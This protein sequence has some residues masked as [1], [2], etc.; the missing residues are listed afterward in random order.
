M[1]DFIN[2]VDLLGDN[3][4]IDSI[5]QR[6]IA[7]FKDDKLETIGIS[8]FRNCSQLTTVDLPAARTMNYHAFADCTSLVDVNLPLCDKVHQYGFNNCTSLTELRLPSVTQLNNGAFVNCPSLRKLD[9]AAEIIR[10]SVFTQCPA[11]EALIFRSTNKVC[12]MQ[13]PLTDT[14]IGQGEGWIYVPGD[15]VDTYKSATNWST[16][17]NQFRGIVDDEDTLNGIIDETLTDFQNGEITEIPVRAFYKYA[18]LKSAKSTSVTKISESAFENCT[19]LTEVDMPN[20]TSLGSNQGGVLNSYTFRGCTNLASVHMPLLEHVGK[21][22]FKGSGIETADFP[23]LSGIGTSVFEGCASLKAINLPLVNKLPSWAFK[24]TG[25]EEVHL[26]SV[27]EVGVEALGYCQAL[28]IVDLPAVSRIQTG[29]FRSSSAIKALVMLNKDVVCSLDDVAAFTDTPIANGTGYIYVNGDLFDS[30]YYY[31]SAWK[32]FKDQIRSMID[33]DTLDAMLDE[34][35]VDYENNEIESIPARAFYKYAPLKSVKSASVVEIGMDAFSRCTSL[36]VVDFSQ[37]VT[38]ANAAFQF[39]NAMKA[40]VLRNG[41]QVSTVHPSA[42]YS[43][44]NIHNLHTCCFYV[45]RALIEDYKV[46]ENWSSYASQFRAL[47]DYTVDGTITG[48]L[49]E[50]KI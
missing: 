34:T 3:T 47:E 29:A 50:T 20:V 2:T 44:Y 35:L 42:L 36:E 9:T 18:P 24:S 32:T 48:E 7:E 40:I 12:E 27:T 11:L 49:D 38:I 16:Y 28:K 10:V 30:Y 14:K 39:A 1:P 4:V 21:E 43:N 22:A 26:P 8:A 45:P 31:D 37:P 25:L 6:T 33:M 23:L 13:S 5:I 15:L 17:Q 41:E 19:S 46:A